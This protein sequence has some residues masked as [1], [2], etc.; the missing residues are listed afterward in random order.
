MRIKKKQLGSLTLSTTK[1][2][3][4]DDDPRDFKKFEA[5]FKNMMANFDGKQK[6]F[7]ELK[8]MDDVRLYE[9][10]K[11]VKLANISSDWTKALEMRIPD[12]NDG[13]HDH[14]TM[15]SEFNET[16]KEDLQKIEQ[17]ILILNDWITDAVHRVENIVLPIKTTKTPK[18]KQKIE[19]P[20]INEEPST[21]YA[22]YGLVASV[23]LAAGFVIFKQVNK[24]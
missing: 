2:E 24:N 5:V 18:S 17:F 15:L 11:E 9:Y 14:E 3:Q 12:C 20:Q 22:L 1:T 6:E 4:P 8:K 19:L 13:K 23:V 7:E 21:N 16:K 10:N